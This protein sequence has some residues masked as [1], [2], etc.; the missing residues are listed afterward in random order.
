MGAVTQEQIFVDLKAEFS[1]ALD[2]GH[3]RNRIDHHAVADYAR[4]ARAQ[5]ARR[6]QMQDVFFPA[7]NDGVTRVVPPLAPYDHV[8]FGGEH[9]DDFPFPL[10]AP[11]RAEEKADVEG[12]PCDSTTDNRQPTTT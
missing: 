3:K 8:R 2:L 12:H 11:L 1:Q 6:N 10:I 4:F 7:M 9:I 5:D